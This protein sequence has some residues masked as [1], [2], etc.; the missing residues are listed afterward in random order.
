MVSSDPDIPLFLVI[1][2]DIAILLLIFQRYRTPSNPNNGEKD[3]SSES[4]NAHAF[5]NGDTSEQEG[6][7]SFLV[8]DVE[9]T[10]V[11]G[12]DFDWPNE[13]IVSGP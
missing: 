3:D 8:I 7:S 10:C 5:D 11:S 12:K 6:F 13:I 2:L 4:G 1:G 9:A